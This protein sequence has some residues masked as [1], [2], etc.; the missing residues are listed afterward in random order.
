MRAIAEGI[1]REKD[2]LVLGGAW[3]RRPAE[4]GFPPYMKGLS[5]PG[6]PTNVS[7]INIMGRRIRLPRHPALRMALGGALV[8]GGILGFLPV[9]VFWMVPLGVAVL[10]VDFPP[11]RRL[12]R[13]ASVGLGN[14]LHRRFPGQA[15]RFG[16]GKPRPERRNAP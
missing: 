14:W 12:H 10:A 16:Y 13:R 4:T 11:V 6:E 3:R 1:S 2:F 9:L 15:A 7:K 8:G 5:K